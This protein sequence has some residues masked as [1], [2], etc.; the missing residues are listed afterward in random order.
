[1]TS[2]DRRPQSAAQRE[3]VYTELQF[4]RRQSRRV[5]ASGFGVSQLHPSHLTELW[6]QHFSPGAACWARYSKRCRMRP[7]T[8]TRWTSRPPPRR[9]GRNDLRG[10]DCAGVVSEASWSKNPICAKRLCAA[11]TDRRPPP[12]APDWTTPICAGRRSTRR[13][14]PPPRLTRRGATSPKR[15]PSRATDANGQRRDR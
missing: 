5:G 3:R 6:A 4:Q 7:L 13:Y 12:R 8:S 1:V 9:S 2:A 10:V 11:P 14:G 15:L